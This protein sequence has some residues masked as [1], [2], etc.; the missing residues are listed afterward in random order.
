MGL[1]ANS[2][3]KSKIEEVRALIKRVYLQD[4]TP[5]VVGYSGGKDSSVVTQLIFEMLVNLPIEDRRKKVYIISS[6]T[7]V[8]TP[9]V[10]DRIDLSLMQI[11]SAALEK[12]LPI[13]THKVKPLI[14]KSF[15][16]NIIGRGYPSPNQTFRWCTDRLKI[17]PANRYIKEV[18]DEHGEVIMVLGVRDGE[19]ASRDRVLESHTLEGRDLMIHSTLN[20]AYTFAPIRPFG[21]DDVWEYLLNNES[22]WGGDNK[23]LYK[24]YADSSSEECPLVID[25]KTKETAGSCGNSRFGCWS[26]TV[27]KED[28][29]LTGFIESGQE[30]LR[31]LLQFRNW[32]FDIRDVRHKRMKKRSNGNV[33]FSSVKEKDG[34]IIIPAKGARGRIEI[35]INSSLDQDGNTWEIFESEK[36]AKISI[37]RR[38]I[39][40]SS[41]F[42]PFIIAKN[43]EGFGQ[44]GLGP[45][46]FDTRKEMLRKL[47]IT[48]RDLVTPEGKEYSLISL[49]ELSEIRSLWIK[50]G[51]WIDSVRS[52]YFE[53]YGEYPI[54]EENDL[55]LLTTEESDVLK[56]ILSEDDIDIELY[57]KI[58]LLQQNNLGLTVRKSVDKEIER[59]LS[60]DYLHL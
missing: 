34:R 39:D 32:L 31:P 20:N 2:L 33:Y 58:L 9:L 44:L 30:W 23:E 17:D 11:E 59:L 48:Q 15:W 19:S 4:S 22:P 14:S 50:D 49:E 13:T 42:E 38:K 40:L 6:D 25:E 3:N 10:I 55:P 28:K 37:S 36:A 46:T 52:I 8:E 60:Q 43:A 54:L 47:L 12:N 45:Y 56:N 53:V 21:V 5:W 16:T 1:I 57:K 24:M 41:D 51:D 27:V 7:L 26:C 18:V 29:A 35:D